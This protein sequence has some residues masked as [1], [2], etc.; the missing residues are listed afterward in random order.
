MDQARTAIHAGSS[1]GGFARWLFEQGRMPNIV[2]DAPAAVVGDIAQRLLKWC[3][4]P[5]RHTR[6]PGPLRLP[7]ETC[8]TWLLSDAGSLTKAQQVAVNRWLSSRSARH[9]HLCDIDP[10]G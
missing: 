2:V 9:G 1:K 7:D 10:A 5:I 3:A 4:P 8:G 6:L